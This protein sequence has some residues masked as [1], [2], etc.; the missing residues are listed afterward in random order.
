[1]KKIALIF[2]ITFTLTR[3]CVFATP[4]EG[5]WLPMFIKN[6]NYEQMKQLG[7]RLTE[8]QLYNINNSSLKDA[9]VQLGG[10]FCTAEMI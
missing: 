1:M 6:Y 5:M 3:I 2:L 7:L 10:G 8:E 9:I 4:D